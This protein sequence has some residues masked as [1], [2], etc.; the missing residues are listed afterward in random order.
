MATATA[1]TSNTLYWLALALTPGL[2][3]TRGRKLVEH[4]ATVGEIFHAPLTELEALHLQA[5]S[6]QHIALGKSL[7]LAHEEYAKAVAAGVRILSREDQ[8][9]PERLSEIYDPPLVL[10]VRGG[11]QALARPG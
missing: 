8:G 5:Q 1:G 2:G 10:Y 3:P 4:F 7:E 11:V 9:W 6:A